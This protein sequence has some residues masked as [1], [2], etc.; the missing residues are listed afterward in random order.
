MA[1][2]HKRPQDIVPM[3]CGPNPE[4]LKLQ[5][6]LNKASSDNRR[7]CEEQEAL[8]KRV[9][10]ILPSGRNCRVLEWMFCLCALLVAGKSFAQER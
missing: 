4:V 5:S 3:W 9:S 1:V 10:T 8:R 7:L 2:R 6:Q